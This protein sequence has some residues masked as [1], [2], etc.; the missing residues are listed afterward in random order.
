ML[1]QRL[2][3]KEMY[4][5]KCPYTMTPIGICVHNTANDASASNEITY[6]TKKENKNKVS[7][8]VAVDDKEAIQGIP[9]NRNAFA[10]GDGSNGEGNRKYI[11]FE[12]C[13]SKSGGTRFTQAE[14]RCA[15][16]IALIL[17]EK[18]WGIDRVKKHQDFSNK[19]CPHRTLDLGW[20]RF[21]KM[22]QSELDSLKGVT[23]TTD[24]SSNFKVGDK[25]VVS[26][27]ATTY[28][29]GQN[30]ANFVKGSTYTVRE[31]K[32]DRCLLSDIDSWVYNKDLT[33]AGSSI[34]SYTVKVTANT[35]NV[36]SGASTSYDV[37]TTVKKGE[38][39]TI[40][41][42]KNGWGKLKSGVGWISLDYTERV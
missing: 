8:H 40:V 4:Q 14:K 30:I 18:G 7:F 11:H 42:E 37:V 24:T 10:S 3:S 16:E 26:K 12:I 20:S 39:Y 25:V 28:A 38:V 22:I 32:S 17:K 41:E 35:L 33:L 34:K 19:Y 27:S 15:K 21:T 23:S 36:R 1:I 31:V 6:M 9:F 2:L 13:Y 5:Y 29:T